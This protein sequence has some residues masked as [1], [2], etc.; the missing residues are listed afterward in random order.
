MLNNFL[1]FPSILMNNND[2]LKRIQ[3]LDEA[4]KIG[5]AELNALY[6]KQD[7][8]GTVLESI[9]KNSTGIAT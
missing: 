2:I 3:E 4:E 7:E 8:H 9:R 5:N 1:S 6:K